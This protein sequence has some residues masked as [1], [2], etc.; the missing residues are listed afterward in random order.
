MPG[1]TRYRSRLHAAIRR[2]TQRG[3][4]KAIAWSSLKVSIEGTENLAGLTGPYVVVA[5][6]S[7]HIDA[8]LIVCGIPLEVGQYLSTGVAA[9]YF[10]TKLHR[11]AFVVLTFNAFPIERTTAGQR[12]NKRSVALQLLGEGVPLLIFPEASRSRTGRMTKFTPGAAGLSLKTG[13]P[14]VP[15]TVVGAHDAM[16]P[17]RTWPKF[18]RPPVRLVFGAPMLPEPGETPVAFTTR[19]S[20]LIRQTYDQVAAEMGLPL[21]A[22]LPEARRNGETP[23]SEPPV[24]ELPVSEPAASEAPTSEP[25]ASDLQASAPAA[26]PAPGTAPGRVDSSTV[27]PAVAPPVPQ[28]STAAASKGQ[29]TDQ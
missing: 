17:G 24:S 7:S 29:E 26:P 27:T 19:Y 23:A 21:Q 6:H 11:K 15:V 3:I 20:D 13:V 12:R 25:T 4:L 1:T 10:F 22:E 8:T 28:D 9:D 2:V 5:N 14:I 16:P 18:G